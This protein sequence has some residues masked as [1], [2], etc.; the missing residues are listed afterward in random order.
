MIDL[1]IFRPCENLELDEQ[2][3]PMKLD[4]KK[5]LDTNSH[6]SRVTY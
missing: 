3:S 6:Y 1:I 5:Q 2:Y 4:L